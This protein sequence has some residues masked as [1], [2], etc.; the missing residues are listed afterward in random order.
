MWATWRHPF[1]WGGG[2]DVSY[3]TP[4]T[5]GDLVLD[6]R[7]GLGFFCVVLTDVSMFRPRS[8]A[9]DSYHA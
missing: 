3:A 9:W 1:F 4:Q 2:D 5:F 8:N 7:V 6:G